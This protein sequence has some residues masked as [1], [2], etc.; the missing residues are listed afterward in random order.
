[1]WAECRTVTS[2]IR[3]KPILN[4]WLYT[5]CGELLYFTVCF[6]LTV[7]CLSAVVFK[8]F[9][10]VRKVKRRQLLQPNSNFRLTSPPQNLI[11]SFSAITILGL[12]LQMTGLPTSAW[13]YWRLLFYAEQGGP[14]YLSLDSDLLLAGWTVLGSKRGGSE[15][16]RTRWDRPWGPPSLFY[17][18]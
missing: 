15:I 12:A 10:S 14:E 9:H 4:I 5:N 6:V 11:H 3:V 2:T 8:L 7:I 16:F 1:M 18:G 17:S 13:N